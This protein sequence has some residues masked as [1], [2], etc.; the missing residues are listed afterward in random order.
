M[1]TDDELKTLKVAKVMIMGSLMFHTRYFYKKM[2]KRKFVVNRHHE[3]IAG[4]LELVLQGKLVNVIINIAPRY[5]KTEIAVKNFISHALALTASA[6]F[7]HLSFSDSLAL[8]NSDGVKDIL[9]TE[10]YRFMFPNVVIKSGTDSKKKWYTTEG[11]GVYATSTAGQVTGFGAG[12]VD[13][14]EEEINEEDPELAE[15]LDSF[16]SSMEAKEGF[17]GALIIDDPIK[18]EDAESEVKRDRINARWDSTIKNRVNSRNTA[19]IVIGQRTHPNDLC[20]YIMDSEGFT[21]DINEAMKD[22][23]KWFLLSIPAVDKKGNA[24]WDFKHT[25][26][27][28]HK[29]AVENPIVFQT[30]Y[31]QN[32]KPKEGLMYDDFRTY[33]D[34]DSIPTDK[35]TIK[36]YIDTADKGKDFLCSIVY[37]ETKTHIY[38][39]DVVY[40]NLPMKD[41]EPLVAKQIAKWKPYLCKIESNNGGGN[42]SREVERQVRLLGNTKTKFKTFH[43]SKNKEARILNNSNTVTNLCYMPSDWATRWPLFYKSITGYLRNGMNLHDDAEDTLTGV[44][45]NFG[46]GNKAGIVW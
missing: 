32:P 20:G 9:K 10:D 27:E 36:Q 15:E 43:Q 42:F 4:V 31:M 37:F 28:L 16:F 30:Q 26:E 34:L 5:S 46:K 1:Y 23:S 38:I 7:I 44:A 17:G 18:P 8:D 3:I 45:E 41:T 6:R 13:E 40:T 21:E 19:K 12:K 25:I 33:H 24:L 39:L 35:G 22:K 29:M 11:G 2:F 14:E